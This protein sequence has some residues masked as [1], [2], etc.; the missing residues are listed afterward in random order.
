MFLHTN[1]AATPPVP[2]EMSVPVAVMSSHVSEHSML[3]TTLPSF[4]DDVPVTLTSAS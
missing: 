1:V 2:T 4:P 3:T